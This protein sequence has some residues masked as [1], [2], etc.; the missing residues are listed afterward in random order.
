MTIDPRAD[1]IIKKR[2]NA[3]EA[4]L[5]V[6]RDSLEYQ[7]IV[8]GIYLDDLLKQMGVHKMLDNITNFIIKLAEKIK[9]VSTK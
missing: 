8:L 5:P 7:G 1:V 4:D 3:T 2:Y 6:L 9:G